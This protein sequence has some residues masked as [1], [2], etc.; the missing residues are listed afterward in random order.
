MKSNNLILFI[1]GL[2][3]VSA[4]VN[5]AS[6]S[7]EKI[8]DIY[9]I[10]GYDILANETS[11]FK[12]KPVADAGTQW[13]SCTLHT[14]K[15]GAG[16][17]DDATIN[18][19]TNNIVNEIALDLGR[20]KQKFQWKVSC[21]DDNGN[22]TESSSRDVFV[23]T[24]SRIL[25]TNV[26]IDYEKQSRTSTTSRSTDFDL[27]EIFDGQISET[28]IAQN[29]DVR[30]EVEVLNL[31]TDDVD[32]YDAEMDVEL[33]IE[34]LDTY[35]VD[36]E[37]IYF[38]RELDA[39]RDS[40]ELITISLPLEILEDRSSEEF[41]F[42]IRVEGEDGFRD[43]HDDEV[44]LE[45]EVKK[46]TEWLYISDVSLTRKI[47][48]CDRETTLRAKF[49]NAGSKVLDDV[50]MHV[51]SDELGIDYYSEP[52]DELYD[53][54]LEYEIL[55]TNIEVNPNLPSGEYNIHVRFYEDN[56]RDKLID[57]GISLVRLTVEDCVEPTQPTQPQE[58]NDTTNEDN[59]DDQSTQEP[60]VPEDYEPV[61]VQPSKT[62][63]PTTAISDD[64][65]V[66]GLLATLNV[67]LLLVGVFIIVKHLKK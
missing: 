55:S 67:A 27:D 31:W 21:T 10:D 37:E 63:S 57:G 59:N 39:Q 40:R 5:A 13:D 46:P 41:E 56:N 51:Y 50:V 42:E 8:D 49:S 45:L 7:L 28:G 2:I 52:I 30:I 36:D 23:K 44:L 11:V 65:L 60:Q 38:R 22:T 1:L 48:T 17:T 19:I 32:K 62:T 34:S 15:G 29:S 26:E 61:I 25:I 47:L 66:I 53:D 4:S 35:E 20:I 58:P 18:T 16:F 64:L 43:F 9:D 33:F 3:L 54:I 24:N 6:V 12:F 14:N